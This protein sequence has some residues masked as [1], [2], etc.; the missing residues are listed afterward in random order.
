MWSGL[1][2]RRF[3]RANYKC[4]IDIKRKHMPPKATSTHTENIGVGGICV[5]VDEDLK[6]FRD[7]DL[8]IYLESGQP[9]ISCKGSIMWVVRETDSKGKVKYDTGIEFG[10]MKEEDRARIAAIVNRVIKTEGGAA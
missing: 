4:K 3:P 9:P 1:D 8:E 7:V 6:I 2:R 10:D 5:I